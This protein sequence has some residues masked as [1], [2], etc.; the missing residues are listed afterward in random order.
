MRHEEAQRRV[1]KR[2]EEREAGFGQEQTP[3]RRTII[4]S[5]ALLL[6]PEPLHPKLPNPSNPAQQPNMS[7]LYGVGPASDEKKGYL[8]RLKVI[9]WAHQD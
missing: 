6:N 8:R 1:T 2:W 5:S 7:S 4:S 3:D 9:L